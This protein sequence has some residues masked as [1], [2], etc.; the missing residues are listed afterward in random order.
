MIMSIRYVNT[1][2]HWEIYTKDG[3]YAQGINST[4]ADMIKNI[5][6]YV[7]ELEKRYER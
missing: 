1:N 7:A 2:W 3:E 6:F 4:W 5:E